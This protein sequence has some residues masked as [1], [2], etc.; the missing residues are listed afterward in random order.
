MLG[1]ANLR[2]RLHAA[3]PTLVEICPA[4]AYVLED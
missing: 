2:L 3:E 4:Q 1:L